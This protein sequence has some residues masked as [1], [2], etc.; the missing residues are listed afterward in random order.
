MTISGCPVPLPISAPGSLTSEVALANVGIVLG[1]N[2]LA[3]G[4]TTRIGI[5][6]WNSAAS[7]TLSLVTTTAFSPADGYLCLRFDQ[8]VTVPAARLKPKMESLS[9]FL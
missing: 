2:F 6:Y 9:P 7:P 3:S 4:G 5:V 1:W 8:H